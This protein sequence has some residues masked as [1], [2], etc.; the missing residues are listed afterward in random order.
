MGG[1]TSFVFG[2]DRYLVYT[3]YFTKHFLHWDFIHR[4]V[5]TGFGLDRF[6]CTSI[7][8][9]PNNSVDRIEYISIVCLFDDV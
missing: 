4:S 7:L 6:H 9:L 1:K 3:G 5:Y 8:F 2:I